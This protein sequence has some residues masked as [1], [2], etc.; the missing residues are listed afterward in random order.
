[1]IYF[2]RSIVVYLFSNTPFVT[3]QSLSPVPRRRLYLRW[4]DFSVTSEN[5]PDKRP[6]T[7]HPIRLLSDRLPAHCYCEILFHVR[8]SSWLG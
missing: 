8:G 7:F 1:M 4:S 5:L 6:H 2:Y 3:S